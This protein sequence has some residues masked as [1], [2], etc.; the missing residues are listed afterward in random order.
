[1]A[2]LEKKIPGFSMTLFH[3]V[4]SKTF[5][6]SMATIIT[7]ATSAYEH[8]LAWSIALPAIFIAIGQLCQR[9]ATHAQTVAT[10]K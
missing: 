1:M 6:A 10:T 5:W 4:T 9:D 7:T 3:M 8:K 2:L